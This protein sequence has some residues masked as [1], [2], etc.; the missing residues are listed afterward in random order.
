M[1]INGAWYINSLPQHLI[2]ELFDGKLKL[3]PIIPM[4]PVKNKLKDYT[5]DHP[6]KIKGQ[7]LPS[8]FY[9]FYGL[10]KNEESL[11]ETI[12][13]RVS[14]TEKEK[15]ENYISNLEPKTTISEL[16]RQYI[17]DLS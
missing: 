16:I 5:G 4:E 3:A 14:P 1:K 15:L 10:D 12:R 11:S 7:P 6:R 9:P 8:Y 2:I 17:R 13:V